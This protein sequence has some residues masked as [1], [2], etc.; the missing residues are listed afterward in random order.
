MLLYI[1][2]VSFISS[3]Y[4]I[5]YYSTICFLCFLYVVLPCCLASLPSK[6]EFGRRFLPSHSSTVVESLMFH[7]SLTNSSET[8]GPKPKIL[9]NPAM[10]YCVGKQAQ[11]S[12]FEDHQVGVA[13]V[14]G[15]WVVGEDTILYTLG[16][17]LAPKMNDSHCSF[18]DGQVKINT[19]TWHGVVSPNLNPLQQTKFLSS[20]LDYT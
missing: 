15:H 18:L 3:T 17:L 6:S 4:W 8:F 13:C 16:S 1:G 5:E 10:S 11:A 9:F 2:N 19:K 12:D 14:K 7:H 20:N